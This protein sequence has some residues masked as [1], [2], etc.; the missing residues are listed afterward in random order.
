[1]APCVHVSFRIAYLNPDRLIT[2]FFRFCEAL[3]G[4]KSGL[5]INPAVLSKDRSKYDPLRTP[6]WKEKPDDKIRADELNQNFPK[7]P[8]VRPFVMD[9]VRRAGDKAIVSALHR[10]SSTQIVN[11]QVSSTAPALCRVR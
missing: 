10:A 5:R 2:F 9:T 1:M 7:R 3:D 6:A 11:T 8:S 4:S